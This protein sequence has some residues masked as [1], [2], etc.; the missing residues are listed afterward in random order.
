MTL[1][2]HIP[3]NS[4]KLIVSDK[5]DSFPEGYRIVDKEPIDKSLVDADKEFVVV[6]A[7]ST[8]LYRNMYCTIQA[9]GTV[10][11]DNVKRKIIGYLIEQQRSGL[12]GGSADLP[13]VELILLTRKNGNI[14]STYLISHQEQGSLKND[15]FDT[16]GSKKVHYQTRMIKFII[17]NVT[18]E[19][20]IN[21]GLS[22]LDYVASID[23]SV[24]HTSV[25]GSTI[26]DIPN[27]GAITKENKRPG[28]VTPGNLFKCI[29]QLINEDK[30][31]I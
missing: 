11:V 13:D 23:D 31:V 24:G 6:C 5:Q 14:N 21:F 15:T 9:D 3:Y 2:I 27:E 20:S 4:G 29:T 1:I 7:G 26:I 17:D 30:I 18:R 25:F 10:N 12:I 22:L 8:R 28:D 19:D 16:I